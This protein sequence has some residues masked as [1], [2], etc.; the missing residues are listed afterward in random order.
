MTWLARASI[1]YETV[2]RLRIQDCYDWHQRAW[3]MFPGRPKGH[4]RTFLFRVMEKDEGVDFWLMCREEPARPDWVTGENWKV[5]LVAESFPFHRRYRFDLVANPTQR[6]ESRDRWQGRERT[7]GK[8]RRFN[9]TDVK[10][11]RN[12]LVNKGGKHGFTLMKQEVE[13]EEGGIR[14]ELILEM[15]PRRDFRFTRKDKSNGLHVGVRYRGYLEVTDRH[16]FAETFK[17][18]IGPAKSFGFGLLLLTPVI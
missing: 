8:H 17:Q 14:E 13:D 15:D 2:A 5:S 16:T 12:W 18:G 4:P 11:Q 7:R 1:D 6:D 9:L 10:E 3:E